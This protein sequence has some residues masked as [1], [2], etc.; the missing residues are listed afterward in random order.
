MYYLYGWKWEFSDN[1]Y[2]KYPVWNF[3][4]SAIGAHTAIRDGRAE[5]HYL[6]IKFCS[7]FVNNSWKFSLVM[8]YTNQWNAWNVMLSVKL[9]EI[10]G[11]A[12]SSQNRFNLHLESRS[13][14]NRVWPFI[15][16]PNLHKKIKYWI[17]IARSLM[18]SKG[19]D[20]DVRYNTWD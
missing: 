11:M 3:N 4:K 17:V 6:H 1:F 19:C 10:V 16:L 8:P 9:S 5:T 12:T 13:T 14:E 2:W 7:C 18:D 20:D 15:D